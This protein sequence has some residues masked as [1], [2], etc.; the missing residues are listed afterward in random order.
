MSYTIQMAIQEKEPKTKPEKINE[1]IRTLGLLA[2]GVKGFLHEN[3]PPTYGNQETAVV[4]IENHSARNPDDISQIFYYPN[5]KGRNEFFVVQRVQSKDPKKKNMKPQLT[6]IQW[7]DV[8][9]EI[10]PTAL[11]KKPRQLSQDEEIDE[12]MGDL[13]ILMKNPA[14]VQIGKIEKGK[15]KFTGQ[16]ERAENLEK[17]CTEKRKKFV[18]NQR[19]EMIADHLKGDNLV[20]LTK[21]LI[22]I[23]QTIGRE[24]KV[25]P[26]QRIV[27]YSNNAN[28][29]TGDIV[30]FYFDPGV[31]ESFIVERKIQKNPETDKDTAKFSVRIEGKNI[32]VS[33]LDAMATEEER[34]QTVT[35]LV[36]FAVDAASLDFRLEY[37]YNGHWNPIPN[38]KKMDVSKPKLFPPRIIREPR[39]I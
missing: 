3:L 2:N 30:C 26:G 35:A 14:T 7:N 15:P 34:N 21:Q 9:R 28:N 12:V 37:P 27:M 1:H 18:E 31:Y 24:L 19:E 11:G 29:E 17:W 22:V 32:L 13:T 10:E 6:N 8:T 4:K 39:K 20:Y 36:R 23:A 5:I 33:P 25:I 38:K 16:T